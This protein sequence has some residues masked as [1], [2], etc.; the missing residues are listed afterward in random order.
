MW[1]EVVWTDIHFCSEFQT[2]LRMSLFAI[3]YLVPKSAS[4]LTRILSSTADSWGWWQI[5]LHEMSSWP[6]L[7]F[8][9]RETLCIQS[10][11][12][13]LKVPVKFLIIMNTGPR[14][15]TVSHFS[16]SAQE[17]KDQMRQQYFNLH[18]FTQ[19]DCF[20][21]DE[22]LGCNMFL[23]T[24]PAWAQR[25]PL[26]AVIS[27]VHYS[28]CFP[29]TLVCCLSSTKQPQLWCICTRIS[30]ANHCWDLWWNGS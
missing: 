13:P 8:A 14:A 3:Q 15:P 12:V 28:S 1:K 2:E 7:F 16:V 19:R 6:G 20:V 18:H 11:P 27:Q 10:L 4:G 26:R 5:D 9:N 30:S 25:R 24:A 22:L 21:R 23:P 29:G 17:G